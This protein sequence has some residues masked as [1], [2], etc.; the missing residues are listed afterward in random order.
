MSV[1]FARAS[2]TMFLASLLLSGSSGI[3][4]IGVKQPATPGRITALKV[5]TISPNEQGFGTLEDIFAN[6]KGNAPVFAGS[7]AA[8]Y[9][10][11]YL[12]VMV[13]VMSDDWSAKVQLTGTEG[14]KVVFN[15]IAESYVPFGGGDVEN[16]KTY[17]LFFIE[18][19][20][21]DKI[22]L[23]ARLLGQRRPSTMTKI[24]E[25]ACGE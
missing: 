20:R 8:N 11:H 9:P 19:D 6:Q 18:G 24:V 2:I 3:A 5:S 23:T 12:L 25:F 17:A 15:K 16:V 22:K 4:A 14:R 21:C 13:E 7:G 10:T 1:L